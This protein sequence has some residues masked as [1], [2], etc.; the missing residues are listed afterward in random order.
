MDS[1]Q[2]VTFLSMLPQPSRTVNVASLGVELSAMSNAV[3]PDE[4]GGL[5]N[6]VELACRAR[7]RAQR[8]ARISEKSTLEGKK[9]DKWAR[10]LFDD[11]HGLHRM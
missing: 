10:T 4:T 11:A 8:V 3:Q 6:E 2:Q 5:R 1:G 7:S 9:V